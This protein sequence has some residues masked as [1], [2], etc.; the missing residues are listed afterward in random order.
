MLLSKNDN[1]QL[2]S[3]LFFKFLEI[4]CVAIVVNATMLM[5]LKGIN[6]AAT[7]GSRFPVT[8]KARPV[9]L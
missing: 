8:A 3:F 6:I 5:E 9:M 7:T 1:R 2:S 4:H